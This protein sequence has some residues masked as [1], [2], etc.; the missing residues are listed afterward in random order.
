MLARMQLGMTEA[1]AMR[2][3]SI[4]CTRPCWSTTAILS[5]DEP[6]LQVPEMCCPVVTSRAQKTSRASSEA[7]SSSVGSIRYST[8]S[9]KVSPSPRLTQVRTISRIRCRS[10][11]SCKYR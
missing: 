3:L 4:P 8:N 1:S 10:K 5:E 9:L 2:S 7:N 6:I 11:G